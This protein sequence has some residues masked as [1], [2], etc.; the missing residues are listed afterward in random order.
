MPI[1]IVET[2]LPRVSA[3]FEW[4]TRGG[5]TLFT[6]Q[7]PIRADGT[8]ETGDIAAQ[9]QLVLENLRRT[10]EAAGGTMRDL[11]QVLV[12]V[13]DAADIPKMN[14][15]YGRFFTAPYPN[16]ATMVVAGL[17]IAGMRIELVA[18]AHLGS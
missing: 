3:P 13:T 6:A 7:V 8:I 2:G 10:V 11:A 5:N 14:E 9:T 4:A 17:A 12:Y 18:Y 16:R 1:A 15:V